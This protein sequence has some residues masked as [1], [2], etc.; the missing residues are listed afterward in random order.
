MFIADDLAE[1]LV[2]LLADAGRKRLTTWVLGD[3]QERALRQVAAAAVHLTAA[4]LRP[5]D[6]EGT[7]DLARIIS[8]V[9]DVPHPSLA[10]QATLLEAL[11]AGVEEQLSVLDD[12]SLTG[13][14]TS[15]AGALGL[16]AGEVAYPLVSHL[17]REIVVRGTRR[18][19]LE[20]LAAQ[21]NHDITHLQGQQALLYGQRLEGMLAELADSFRKEALSG[22]QDRTD[23][24]YGALLSLLEAQVAISRSL[25]YWPFNSSMPTLD[26]LY[27]E[28]EIVLNGEGYK[29][30]T[31]ILR[32]LEEESDVVL[33][34]GAGQGKS[35]LGIQTV[36]QISGVTLSHIRESGN[37]SGRI[38]LYVPALFMTGS[39]S[40]ASLLTRALSEH[41]T[42][43]LRHG[44]NLA[45]RSSAVERQNLLIFIDG[46]D[47]I[48]DVRA[49]GRLA[50]LLA[51]QASNTQNRFVILTRP[52]GPDVMR[53]IGANAR[54]YEFRSDYSMRDKIAHNWFRA[55][56]AERPDVEV[57]KFQ[58]WGE[59][60]G[61]HGF[62]DA[63]LLV[64]LALLLF[65]ADQSAPAP[66]TRIELYDRAVQIL[67]TGRQDRVRLWENTKASLA[68]YGP[69]GAALADW[70]YE[71]RLEISS[72]IAY[73]LLGDSTDR[74]P[75]DKYVEDEPTRSIL[76]MA[77]EF[78]RKSA[79]INFY[80]A[81]LPGYLE[82]L[83]IDT[84]LFSHRDG[85]LR[86]AHR[87]F[88]EYLAAPLAGPP[89]TDLGWKEYLWWD[90][91]YFNFRMLRWAQDHDAA[92][93]IAALLAD[94]NGGSPLTG[95]RIVVDLLHEGLPLDNGTLAALYP[96]LVEDHEHNWIV[97]GG[98]VLDAVRIGI[99]DLARL[100][101]RYPELNIT[102]IEALE[103]NLYSSSAVKGFV[104]LWHS[105]HRDWCA[106]KITEL[107]SAEASR[108]RVLAA[109]ILVR[110]GE[111]RQA[112]DLAWS[113]LSP[114]I[115]PHDE[116]PKPADYN[117][118]YD[119]AL[120]LRQQG[121]PRKNVDSHIR[122][123]LL[124]L[125]KRVPPGDWPALCTITADLEQLGEEEYARETLQRALDSID[126]QTSSVTAVLCLLATRYE[127]FTSLAAEVKRIA[128]ASG[129]LTEN[130]ERVLTDIDLEDWIYVWGTEI[131]N[132]ISEA[133][134]QPAAFLAAW[135]PSRG[136]DG[137][138]HYDFDDDGAGRG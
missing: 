54:R 59:L 13:I 121:A 135:F 99:A 49:R 93:L 62:F 69:S 115:Y 107:R 14:G 42:G 90:T 86:F 124:A 94:G 117:G 12:S 133:G 138:S 111:V 32:A 64:T 5:G 73:S 108:E 8:Q 87:T 28:P 21:L 129:R 55:R 110:I 23:E 20:P 46:L 11:R 26:E 15:A 17:L 57:S 34:A 37:I 109:K 36:A 7:D 1:W 95:K 113:V 131:E 25:P 104:A 80:V 58:S 43:F 61:S 88:A 67:L 130:A 127:K 125:V 2:G 9:F 128:V 18:G 102:L 84:G 75:R 33:V 77:E 116:R 100:A 27:V 53:P 114:G 22:P 35:T 71:H 39:G 66:S 51:H 118:L 78:V 103:K 79:P 105:D 50:N 85:R 30:R 63:P 3:D 81:D 6:D 91:S 19:P 92:P 41:L 70:L 24:A 120:L 31:T 44:V 38:P 10:G 89:D 45:L 112:T 119:A 97:Y 16:S 60:N 29:S 68:A 96:F 82:L 74:S 122:D 52:L 72:H 48:A 106:A 101:A 136:W 132:T 126:F 4:E 83:L 123:S 137:Y 65:E 134:E 98:P 56:G 40:F 76:E 47:E